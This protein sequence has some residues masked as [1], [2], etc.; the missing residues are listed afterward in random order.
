MPPGLDGLLLR[1]LVHEIGGV[2]SGSRIETVHQPEPT[3]LYLKI[4]PP[5]DTY[6]AIEVSG[7]QVSLLLTRERPPSPLTPPRFCQLVRA[8]LEGAIVRRLVQPGMDRVFCLV[9]GGSRQELELI[10]ELFGPGRDLYLVEVETRRL[11]GR[12]RD[13]PPPARCT[14]GVYRA[15]ESTGPMASALDLDAATL[16]SHLERALAGPGAGSLCREIAGIGGGLSRLA[17]ELARHRGTDHA[18]TELLAYLDAVRAHAYRPAIVCGPGPQRDLLLAPLEVPGVT[19]VESFLSVEELARR[20]LV[21][22]FR[23]SLLEQ[24]RKTT[25][26]ALDRLVQ[27]ER[28][29]LHHTRTNLERAGK[30]AEWERLGDLLKA[31]L[32][33]VKP[34]RDSVDVVDHSSPGSPTVAVAIKPKLSA[35]HNMERYYLK[36]KKLR[37]SLPALEARLEEHSE[38]LACLESLASGLESAVDRPRIEEL[39]REIHRIGR[40]TH[41]PRQG[42][43]ADAG[44]LEFLSSEGYR[45]LV[46]RNARENDQLTRKQARSQDMW[47]HVKDLPGSHVL[48]RMSRRDEECPPGT[49]E[50]AAQLAA[51]YSK[52]RYA[53]RVEVMHTRAGHVKK[54]AGL[55]AG[56]VV[57]DRHRTIV[58]RTDP[59]ITS[60]LS[61]P[62]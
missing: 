26:Q 42:P 7:R 62:I 36:A 24:R 58:V 20:V 35:R 18:A 29:R 38:N 34:Y 22:D 23:R 43:S 46:G 27:R 37:R 14:G 12:L 33:L 54:P 30:A 17:L 4:F 11:L 6:L 1:A 48:V 21:E 8:R 28:D 50:E 49:L 56:E 59:R 5:R 41:G 19:V 10:G 32:A 40:V 45:I 3:T 2:I 60:K 9:T 15:P 44:P 52:A 51:H 61:R 39:E 47:L 31:N 53:A 16:S 13:G 55:P 57:V 25:A